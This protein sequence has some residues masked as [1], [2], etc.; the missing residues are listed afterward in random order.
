MQERSLSDFCIIDSSNNV[1]NAQDLSSV[2]AQLLENGNIQSY[3]NFSYQHNTALHDKL[4]ESLTVIDDVFVKH[5]YVDFGA[6]IDCFFFCNPTC[7]TD[8][9]AISFNG[10]KDCNVLLHL[11]FLYVHK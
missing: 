1:D 7:R 5:G 11:L 2:N 10:G 3:L 9:I 4:V 8:K 6:C